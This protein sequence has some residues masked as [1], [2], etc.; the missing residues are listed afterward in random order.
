MK[1][2][3]LRRAAACPHKE[4]DSRGLDASRAPQALIRTGSAPTKSEEEAK[5]SP[6]ESLSLF[7]IQFLGCSMVSKI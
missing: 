5:N 3:S 6:M 7:L 1:T 2:L 4:G